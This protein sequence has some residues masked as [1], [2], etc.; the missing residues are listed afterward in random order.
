MEAAVVINEAAPLLLAAQI[1]KAPR[2]QD[3][4][5]FRMP[6]SLVISF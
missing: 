2:Y 5:S 4:L 1:V 3:N 6:D